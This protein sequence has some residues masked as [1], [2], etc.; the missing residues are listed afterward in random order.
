M[1]E[2]MSGKISGQSDYV[3]GGINCANITEI[4]LLLGECSFLV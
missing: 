1:Y 2:L 3:K 4:K